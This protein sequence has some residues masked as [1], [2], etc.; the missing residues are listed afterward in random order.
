MNILQSLVK[1]GVQELVNCQEVLNWR[2]RIPADDLGPSP[3]IM[4][5]R[6]APLDL[7]MYDFG[8]IPSSNLTFALGGEKRPQTFDTAI[9][10]S[11]KCV[12]TPFI[13]KFF[14]WLDGISL[15]W[16]KWEYWYRLFYLHVTLKQEIAGNTG[17]AIQCAFFSLFRPGNEM[18]WK[19]QAV[20]EISELLLPEKRQRMKK[21]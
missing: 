20:R 16:R 9:Y 11:N 7:V 10:S 8:I 3:H 17:W 4:M 21:I 2:D 13:T 15:T 14:P 19:C 12:F 6:A 18:K 1:A 5:T